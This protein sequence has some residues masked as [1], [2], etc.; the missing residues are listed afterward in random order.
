MFLFIGSS[1]AT[2]QPYLLMLTAAQV[3]FVPLVLQLLFKT[4]KSLNY[5]TIIAMLSVFIVQFVPS[6]WQQAVLASIYLLFTLYVGAKG[7]KRFLARGFT[8]WAELS[9][10]FGL[11][12]L[13]AGGLWFFAWISGMDTGFSP[14][15]TWLTAIHFHY[16]AFLLPISLGFFGRI[17][18]S[19]WYALVVPIILAGPMLVAIGLTFWPLLEVI[20]VVLYVIAIYGLIILSFRT[21]F[22][23]R[24]QAIL[25]RLSYSTLG[26]TILFS[27]LYAAN[28]F[29][30]W[31]VTIDFM[32]LFH[33]LFNCILFG[34]V[35]VLGWLLE[36]PETKLDSWKFPVSQVRGKLKG[37]G[38]PHPGLVDDLGAFVDVKELPKTIVHFYEQT[39][40]YRVFGSVK[41][42]AWF[43]PIALVYKIIS[44]QV[45]QLN[46][47][48]SSRSTE[49]TFTLSRVDPALDT[50]FLP[51]AWIRR[52]KENTVFTA[53]YSQHQ[54]EGRTYM[55][56]ALPL[57]FST[58]IGILQLDAADGKLILS[59]EGKG[60]PGIYLAAGKT[61]FKLPL[62]ELF[63]I[64]ETGDGSLAAHHK[65]Q[66]FG[67][68]FLHIDY[69]IVKKK[70]TGS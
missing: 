21:R 27:F 56:I 28:M 66:I 12:Y 60:D 32:L 63:L 59:S 61:L 18:N 16:S 69:S 52:V 10:D 13:V 7:L 33:G 65:M 29:G 25:I 11:M 45:Q 70:L 55:N 43:L 31:V 64:K 4:T 44:R 35:G 50:R 5:F 58:M 3:L 40:Q 46:L 57:P 24:V 8:N 54:T 51:R 37:T 22:P 23:S 17:Q 62:S 20:S 47:P 48:L 41:W 39:H 67:L 53:I 36:L 1:L 68:P 14:M 19:K 38:K 30:Y 15:I 6:G 2:G 42:A 26:F 49:M 34:L 9:I